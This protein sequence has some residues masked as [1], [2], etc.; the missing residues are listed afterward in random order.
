M[1]LKPYQWWPYEW[2]TGVIA[3]IS[4]VITLLLTSRSGPALYKN[5]IQIPNLLIGILN[6]KS[7]VRNW[8]CCAGRDSEKNLRFDIANKQQKCQWNGVQV[9][10]CLV[11]NLFKTYHHFAMFCRSQSS[12]WLRKKYGREMEEPS[13]GYFHLFGGLSTLPKFMGRKTQESIL[14]CPWHLVTT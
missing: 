13:L 5:T 3:P 4:G 9:T 14:G 10:S 7:F 8:F 6:L 1:E 11:S 2:V 12:Y